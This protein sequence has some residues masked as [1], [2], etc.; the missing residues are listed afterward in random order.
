MAIL[1]NTCVFSEIRVELNNQWYLDQ[2]NLTLTKSALC[3]WCLYLFFKEHGHKDLN[4][5]L[6]LEGDPSLWDP[7]MSVVLTSLGQMQIIFKQSYVR[8]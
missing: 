7:G 1:L 5:A 2:R 8:V 3:Y 4:M 6:G